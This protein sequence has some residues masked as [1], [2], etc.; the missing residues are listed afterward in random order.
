MLQWI[1]D[2]IPLHVHSTQRKKNQILFC[3]RTILSKNFSRNLATGAKKQKIK[4]FQKG[5]CV[6]LHIYWNVLLLDI[7]LSI[8]VT[9]N[10]LWEMNRQSML[11]R[12]ERMWDVQVCMIDY[13]VNDQMCG[14]VTCAPEV[15]KNQFFL[16]A[17]CSPIPTKPSLGL[18]GPTWLLLSSDMIF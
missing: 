9:K 11:L 16:P 2:L 3:P 10:G 15:C 14:S 6:V 17:S 5:N 1:T 4:R 7:M 18:P 13:Y 8:H 12:G